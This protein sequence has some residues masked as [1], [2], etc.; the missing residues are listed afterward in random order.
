MLDT[1]N[2]QG[3]FLSSLCLSRYSK[4]TVYST[5]KFQLHLTAGLWAIV[6]TGGLALPGAIERQ[7][8]SAWESMLRH[9]L[10]APL[11]TARM[12]IPLLRAKRGLLQFWSWKRMY[13]R[14]RDELRRIFL[15][16][17]FSSFFLFSF[18]RTHRSF[19]RFRDKLRFENWNRAGSVQRFQEGRR[20][21]CRSIKKWTTILWGRRRPPETAARESPYSL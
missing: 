9:N 10:V 4:P 17:F 3:A 2:V 1:F 15:L 16:F 6:H 21:S 11:R 12:F 8:S 20:R 14:D 18:R 5:L 19:G 13:I 7:P